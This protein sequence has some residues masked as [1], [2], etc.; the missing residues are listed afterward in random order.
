MPLIYKIACMVLIAGFL[1]VGVLGLILPIIPG[2]L[3]LFLAV[4]LL[5]RV[6]RRAA[7]FAHSKPW[8]HKNMHHWQATGGLS[9]GQRV[10]LGFLMGARL[11]VRTAQHLFKL[12]SK[13][14]K[15]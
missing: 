10:K 1:I 3:F 15:R 6:S 14:G 9:I 2:L 11:I 12:A 5:T 8:F 4:L 7:T 13:A